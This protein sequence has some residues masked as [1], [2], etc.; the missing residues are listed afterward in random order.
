M[1]ALKP[2]IIRNV[3]DKE[4]YFKLSNHFKNIYKNG[5]YDT[6]F[7]RYCINEK[8]DLF[9]KES[10]DKVLEIAKKIFNNDL[11]LPSYA[12]FA[13]YE[14]NNEVIPSLIHHKDNNAC[15]YTI[16]LCLYQTEPWDLYIEGNPYTL[17][18][19]EALAYYG[20]AQEHWRNDMPNP[21]EQY[22]AM[23]FFHF[24]EPGHWYH[25]KG[26]DY[27]DVVLGKI[28]EEQWIT[29]HQK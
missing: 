18:I 12:F 22:V 2:K 11:L 28:T 29:N 16:D 24:V 3:F 17:D 23:V 27:H 13:H 1:D 8:N 19:N 20:C 14:K 26:P 10:F 9:L 6:I 5:N 4:F 7:G 15:T 21:D 25:D